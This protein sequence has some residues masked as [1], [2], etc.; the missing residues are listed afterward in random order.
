MDLSI[1]AKQVTK[2]FKVSYEEKQYCRYVDKPLFISL[3]DDGAIRTSISPDILKEATSGF[4][5]LQYEQ[6]EI[7]NYYGW[8]KAFTI[9]SEGNVH[10]GINFYGWSIYF[11]NE[12]SYSRQRMELVRNGNQTGLTFDEDFTFGWDKAVHKLWNYIQACANCQS[13]KERLFILEHLKD[14][15]E[16][17]SLKEENIGLEFE[18]DLLKKERE[19]YKGVLDEIKAL[20]SS[21]HKS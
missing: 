17:T 21:P 4:V 19:L 18:N 2:D 10:H 14:N 1:I 3:Q 15:D 7:S 6:K 5:I 16:I 11:Y 8:S 12:L 9:D 13:D 20:L